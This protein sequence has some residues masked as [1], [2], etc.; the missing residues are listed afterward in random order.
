MFLGAASSNAVGE[1]LG[2]AIRCA[3]TSFGP[4]GLVQAL[5]GDSA[6]LR[7][8]PASMLLELARDRL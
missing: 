3:S 7:R 1:S 5:G 8:R 4:R 6:S 2:V